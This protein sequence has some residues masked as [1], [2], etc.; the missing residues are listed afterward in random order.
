MGADWGLDL[1]LSGFYDIRYHSA[2]KSA[3]YGFVG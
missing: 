2:I 1:M 3:P